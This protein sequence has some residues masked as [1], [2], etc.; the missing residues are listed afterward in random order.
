[1]GTFIEGAIAMACWVAGLFFLR[2]WRESRE[3][4]FLF[5]FL[6]FWA[7]CAHWVALAEIRPDQ[8]SRHYFY[9]LRL[10]AFAL[11]ASGIVDRNRRGRTG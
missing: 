6:A 9:L 7:L 5:F 10:A 2:F 11:I 8:Q 3:R 1:M 4:L